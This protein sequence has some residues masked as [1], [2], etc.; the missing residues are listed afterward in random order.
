MSSTGRRGKTGR[1]NVK[2]MRE[3][4]MTRYGA[5]AK[6][7]PF[8]PG[9]IFFVLNPSDPELGDF[10]SEF[11]VDRDGVSRVYTSLKEAYDATVTNRNDVIVLN[12][13][14]VHTL[15]AMLTVSKSRVHFI[16]M[17]ALNGDLRTYGPASKINMGV[18]TAITDV[19]MVK[20][21]GVRNSFRGIK[22]ANDNT[23]TQNV[24]AVGEGGEYATYRNCEF[25][26]STR[27]TSDTHAELVLNGDSAQFYGCTFG[28]LA[29]AV[30]GDKIRPAVLM[31]AGT[32]D[33]AL[34]SR[35]VLFDNCK[36][37]KKAGGTTTAFIKIAASADLERGMELKDC[38]F[39]ASILGSTPAVAIDSATLTNGNI[40]LTG[41]TVACKCTKIATAT[42]ILNGTPAR[43]ATATIAIQAT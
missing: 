18:T 33:T 19:F 2:P 23:L 20:N 25:Y 8:T 30:S 21:T 28:S 7:L 29:D 3:N 15:T 43:V 16:G 31:T 12:G 10:M 5:I 14:G 32:V 26:D 24:A 36:F 13:N 11:P 42:G 35:D 41:M 1:K 40:L 34:V 38:T 4:Q 17:D 37:W 27:L 6:A 22:F 39:I 9:K